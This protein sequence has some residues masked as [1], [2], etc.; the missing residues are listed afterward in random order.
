MGERGGHGCSLLLFSHEEEGEGR[1]GGEGQ[2]GRERLGL[3]WAVLGLFRAGPSY[4]QKWEIKERISGL[5][6][7]SK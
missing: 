3:V 6:P 2:L 1:P 5:D 4:G 7:R